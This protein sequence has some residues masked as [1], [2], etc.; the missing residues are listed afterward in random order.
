MIVVDTTVLVYAVGDD[1]HLRDPCRRLVLAVRE[2]RLDATTSV[3][4]VQEFV[5]VR[6]RRRT[7]SDAVDLG[8]SY[9]DLFGPLLQATPDD[10]E[11]GLRLF[12]RR[13]Q[14]GAFDSVLVAVAMD[15]DAEAI[16]SAD[17]GF[18]GIRGLPYVDPAGPNLADVIGEGESL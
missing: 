12:L 13:E 17:A 1:H 15:R 18:D 4:V 10:L 16:V 11:R 3:E 6:A 8:R 5:H 7:R 2:G 14:L 9:A